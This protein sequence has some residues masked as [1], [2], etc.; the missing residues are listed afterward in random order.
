MGLESGG[1]EPGGLGAVSNQ[2]L[3]AAKWVSNDPDLSTDNTTS[4]SVQNTSTGAICFAPASDGSGEE[5]FF[6]AVRSSGI[7]EYDANGNRITQ[8]GTSGEQ[9]QG[10]EFDWERERFLAGSRDNP[11]INE[12]DISWSETN[13]YGVS[14]NCFG[15]FINPFIRDEPR[16]IWYDQ[17]S[18]QFVLENGVVP[19]DRELTSS[20]NESDLHGNI[21]RYDGY[22]Y[23]SNYNGNEFTVYDTGLTPVKDYSSTRNTGGLGIGEFNGDYGMWEGEWDSSTVYYWPTDTVE[24]RDTT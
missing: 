19:G 9:I 22:W 3:Y 24:V 5:H 12:Y 16:L 20:E 11:V 6:I 7:D 15:L 1:F 13:S 21:S 2:G 23:D 18:N 14:G 10:L 4:Y 17:N 8:H